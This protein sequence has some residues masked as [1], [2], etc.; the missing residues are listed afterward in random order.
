MILEKIA[1]DFSDGRQMRRVLFPTDLDCQAGELIVLSG[2][3]EAAK[4][5]CFLSWVG[6][7]PV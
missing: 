2:P 7:K 6:A 5:H 3:S 4:P 1:K